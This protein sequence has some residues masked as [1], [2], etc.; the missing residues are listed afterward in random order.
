[1]NY[2]ITLT[3]SSIAHTLVL[4]YIAAKETET[5]NVAHRQVK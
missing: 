2:N 1:M 5:Y 3:N 4:L